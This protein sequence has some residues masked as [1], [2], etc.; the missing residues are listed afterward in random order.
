MNQALITTIEKQ[1]LETLSAISDK[2]T[3]MRWEVQFLG[4]KSELSNMLKDVKNLTSEQKRTLAPKLQGLRQKL[5]TE[6]TLKQVEIENNARDWE[7][8]RVDVQLYVSV[9]AP[10][11]C[12]TASAMRSASRLTATL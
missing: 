9:S 4:R 7:G 2:E 10:R 8:D 6:L 1:A 11:A 5:T 12:S 3:L